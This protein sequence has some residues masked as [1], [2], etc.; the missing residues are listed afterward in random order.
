MAVIYEVEG[1]V[2]VI[3]INRP[4]RRN[5]VDLKTANQLI[6]AFKTFEA[7]KHLSV[8]VFTGKGGAF[9]A[10]A[11]LHA[12]SMGESKPVQE[13]GDFAPMGPSRLRLSKP[14]VAAVEGPAVAGGLELALWADL[15]VAAKSAVFGVYCRRF[16]VPLIDLGTIRLPRL[17]GQ[18]R[19]SD[20]ILT[21]RAVD[22]EEAFSFGLVN[23]IVESGEALNASK[24]MARQIA[25]FPQLCLRNDRMSMLEQWHLSE[26]DALRNEIKHGRDTIR[27]GETLSGATAFARGKGRHGS[28]D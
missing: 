25:A 14:V 19:A 3:S 15:R 24:A 13:D 2:V 23:R 8:A 27:S 4:E 7:D 12:I 18:S 20:M 10:G 22:A 16:G 5:A 17:I 21:G 9:C 11:D 26:S 28:F 6:D 1:D